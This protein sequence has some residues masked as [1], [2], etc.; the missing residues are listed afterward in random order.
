ML[1][2]NRDGNT[3]WDRDKPLEGVNRFYVNIY[4]FTKMS[5]LGSKHICAT[6]H[7]AKS[8]L[9]EPFKILS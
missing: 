7:N 2:L 1:D 9:K 8:T 6:Q 4:V 5:F 3:P